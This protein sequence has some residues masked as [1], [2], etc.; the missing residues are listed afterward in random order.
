MGCRD[1]CCG[2][3]GSRRGRRRGVFGGAFGLE[4]GG[5][6]DAVVAVSAYGE[7]LGVVLE[8]VGRGFGALVD[9]GEFAALLEEIEGGVGA[10]AVDAARSYVAGY[11]EVANVCL[12]A[13]ALEFA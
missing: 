10:D 13:H 7:G 11:T 3:G 1:G 5:V 9:D 6:E 4:L 8:C 2:G 12:I